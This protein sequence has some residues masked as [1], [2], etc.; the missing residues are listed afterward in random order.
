[1][2]WTDATGSGTTGCLT[3]PS[4]ISYR[5]GQP[6]DDLRGDRS[7]V[8]QTSTVACIGSSR[9]TAPANVRSTRCFGMGSTL[10]A[11]THGA[12]CSR[13]TQ[14]AP[15]RGPRPYRL[16]QSTSSRRPRD[17]DVPHCDVT[18]AGTHRSASTRSVATATVS[19][20][21]IGPTTCVNADAGAGCELHRRCSVQ[22]LTKGS[23]SA[24]CGYS[25]DRAAHT[26]CR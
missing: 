22:S 6:R 10:V 11:V 4:T 1:V 12:A 3:R 20:F 25:K 23:L 15:D 13:S 17:D 24:T 16:R 9:R 8:F 21:R 5:S 7:R 26:P 14:A 18:N 2:T 19:S